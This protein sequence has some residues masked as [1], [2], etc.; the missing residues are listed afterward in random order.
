IGDIYDR[1]PGPHRIMDFLMKYHT[2]DIQ[3]GNHDVLWMGA[4]GGHR[5]CIA[6]VVRICARYNNLDVLE[7]GYGINLIP[8]ARFAL[9]VY[10]DDP[11]ELFHVSGDV[12]K[13][14]FREEELN[15]KMHKAITIIQFKLEGQ[16]IKRR[17]DF[18]MQ[19][20]LLLDKVDYDKGT[21]MI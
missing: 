5:A 15:K 9:D 8:L 18:K 12:P 7:N 21:I 11:C 1:G 17:P 13:E 10:G 3:W 16:L 14:D 2:V 19:D 6:N 4:A 20:R